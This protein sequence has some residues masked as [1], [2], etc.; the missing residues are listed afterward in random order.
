MATSRYIQLTDWALLE[1]E[2]AS[3]E[4]ANNQAGALKITNEYDDS[5]QFLNS[6]LAINL[7]GNVQDKSSAH[8][9]SAGNRWAFLDI[10]T[11]IPTIT[12]DPKLSLTVETTNLTSN[13]QYDKVKI[14]IISG[15]NLD[16]LDGIIAQT[17]VTERS[18]KRVDLSNFTFLSSQSDYV[19]NPTP[20]FIG[21]GLYDKYIE[22]K[23]PALSS[24]Q[25]EYYTN[26]ANVGNFGYIY[27]SN[28]EGYVKEGL[29]DFTLHEITTTD[30][31]N[32]NQFFITGNKYETSFLPADQFA[33]L[34]ATV[35]ESDEGDYFEYYGTWDNGFMNDY[36]TR[37][38][39]A[40]ANWAIIH[41]LDIFEQIGATSVKT[42]N[43]TSLQE[44]D[45]DKPNIFR[46]VVLNSAIASSFSIDY[47]MR[48]LNRADGNQILR[49]ASVTSFEPNKYGKEIEK[50]TVSQGYR[51]VKVYN[52]ILSGEE[53]ASSTSY[54]Q[55]SP[56]TFKTQITT[57]YVPNFFSNTNIAI[58][59]TGKDAQELDNSIWGQGKAII[60]LNIFD[61]RIRFRV[62]SRSAGDNEL[63]SLD[64][65]TEPSIILSF[66]YDDGTKKLIEQSVDNDA[67][68]TSGEVEFLIPA[69]LSVDLL[70]QENKKFYLT[71]KGGLDDTETVLYQGSYE[72]FE[73][74]ED[75]AN[76]LTDNQESDLDK[77]ISALR[78]EETKIVE[79][80]NSLAKEQERI[81]AQKKEL[82]K[83]R[84]ATRLADE[85]AAADLQ[86]QTNTLQQQSKQTQLLLEEQT[87]Q[88]KELEEQS[89]AIDEQ[90]KS[91]Q[92]QL[93]QQV[94]DE[95]S[96]NKDKRPNP[97]W[98]Y[99]EI[100]G[101]TY[102]LSVGFKSV[103]PK[104][105]K[106]SK[107]GTSIESIKTNER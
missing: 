83:E 91:L 79:L 98:K 75:V 102:D 67:D 20:V 6:D 57:R 22:F 101:K 5:I 41:Q 53:E 11:I 54:Q 9:S 62:Y 40:G 84:E 4:I 99:R 87:K 77:K 104:V 31:V 88:Q 21:D 61:N 46:P 90:I 52:K 28:N 25:S 36:I 16:G 86:N 7:T 64:L 50:I 58:S 72:N 106:P 60:L 24:I 13:I 89:R 81:D 38:N 74:R 17:S 63:E 39:S 51:P 12:S 10:D 45:F 96:S 97:K 27:S 1:Y 44:F 93:A 18:G 78:V 80:R 29:I 95:I 30:T 66:V 65:T 49:E 85:Q 103:R 55:N 14:H 56:G 15:F 42:W 94:N 37:L 82:E 71:S 32:G 47:T 43:T 34:G 69:E 105:L 35:K 100:P 48:F 73:N 8:Q 33:L 59:T 92:E 26:T 2:Y 70:A 3:E 107:P 76:K 23:V 19:L 68:P